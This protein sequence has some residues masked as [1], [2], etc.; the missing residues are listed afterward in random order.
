M[1]LMSSVVVR[2]WG[3]ANARVRSIEVK[4]TKPVPVGT[5]LRC[6]GK[7][8]ELHPIAPGKNFAV[9]ELYVHDPADQVMGVGSAQVMLPD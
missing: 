7:V 9:V 4:F 5:R 3:A 6:T 2:G 8:K 1:S